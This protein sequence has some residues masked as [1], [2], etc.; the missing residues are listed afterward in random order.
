[1]TCKNSW[2]F[3]LK[4]WF[5]I[6]SICSK[7]KESNQVSSERHYHTLQSFLAGDCQKVTFGRSVYFGQTNRPPPIGLK[8]EEPSTVNFT[9]RPLSLHPL[10]LVN[11]TVK[12][13]GWNRQRVC[14]CR[15]DGEG[16]DKQ[17]PS[18]DADG[19]LKVKVSLMVNCPSVYI[20]V[21]FSFLYASTHSVVQLECT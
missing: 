5:I 19:G 2:L 3:P 6:R 10:G 8:P 9:R 16:L 14:V 11:A 20:L 18:R 12:W 17:W 21:H 4:Q 15:Y 1:M 7:A 13:T